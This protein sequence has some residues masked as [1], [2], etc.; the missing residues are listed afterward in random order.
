MVEV[1]N[2]CNGITLKGTRCTR[3]YSYAVIVFPM[4]IMYFI[5]SVM[6]IK[7]ST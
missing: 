6:Y 2:Q 4:I 5:L 1:L 7:K 3:D